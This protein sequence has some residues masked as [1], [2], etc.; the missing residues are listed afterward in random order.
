MLPLVS[1]RNVFDPYYFK[2][3]GTV[4]IEDL[5]KNVTVSIQVIP[6]HKFIGIRSMDADKYWD[7]WK[8]EE[9]QVVVL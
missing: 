4:M 6:T 2:I 1:K 5:A 8:S 9:V 3:G 7:F